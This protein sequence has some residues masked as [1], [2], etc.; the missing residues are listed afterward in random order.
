MG[1]NMTTAGIPL[2]FLL[3]I[4]CAHQ[5]C[6]SKRTMNLD[7]SMRTAIQMQRNVNVGAAKKIYRRIL[8]ADPGNADAVQL[9]GAIFQ[10][11]GDTA[12]A[13]QLWKKSISLNPKLPQ[14]CRCVEPTLSF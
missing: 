3:A 2:L 6:T 1:H 4:F 7:E 11:E 13:E 8:K 12:R 5:P 9:Y 10:S 14:V